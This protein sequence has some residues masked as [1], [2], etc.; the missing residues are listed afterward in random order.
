MLTDKEI[1]A[2]KDPG[3]YYYA[4]GLQHDD[5]LRCKDC[6]ALITHADLC[7]LGMCR[8]GNRRVSEVVTLSGEEMAQIESGEIDF[9]HRD[10]FLKEFSRVE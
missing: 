1:E 3:R 2:G 4:L 7:R 9:P 10:E 8:C 5:I 6:K